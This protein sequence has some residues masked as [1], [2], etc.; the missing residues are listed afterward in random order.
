MI[1]THRSTSH[2][3]RALINAREDHNKT[4]ETPIHPSALHMKMLRL[5]DIE[6]IPPFG[7]ELEIV[8]PGQT[9]EHAKRAAEILLLTRG[10][11]PFDP[12]D[13][14]PGR[15]LGDIYTRKADKLMHHLLAAYDAVYDKAQERR[16][17]AEMF[18]HLE[19]QIE[20][21]FPFSRNVDRRLL[22]RFIIQRAARQLPDQII[23][24]DP[25]RRKAN[26]A[27]AP[28]PTPKAKGMRAD[29]GLTAAKRLIGSIEKDVHET[30]QLTDQVKQEHIAAR[31]AISRAA[32]DRAAS[33]RARVNKDF[34]QHYR[35]V[36][37]LHT[38]KTPSGDNHAAREYHGTLKAVV[39]SHQT[40]LRQ[41]LRSVRDH[42]RDALAT[43][44]KV[45]SDFHARN[46]QLS[47]WETDWLRQQWRDI[48]TTHY[49]EK[50]APAQ[51]A[52]ID[53]PAPQPFMERLASRSRERA[54]PS[55]CR[56]QNNGHDPEPS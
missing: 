32:S 51:T 10:E 31:I 46:R 35:E 37:R 41:A 34:N 11:A 9:Y 54:A 48:S 23:E 6:I 16:F 27:N 4:S 47:K 52:H 38:E 3:R 22:E 18:D 30:A 50:H 43:A 17:M 42:K 29:K 5:Y 39:R 56:E 21:A 40:V 15:N 33:V 12:I 26:N 13:I 44:D 24:A 36:R 45:L 55:P 19:Y 1:S 25:L 20:A 2:N 28:S 49:R 8:L 7:D 14:S 53:K